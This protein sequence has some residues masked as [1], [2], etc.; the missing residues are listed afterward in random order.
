MILLTSFKILHCDLERGVK[1][2]R[3]KK[4]SYSPATLNFS[5]SAIVLVVLG[6]LFIKLHNALCE[7]EKS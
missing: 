2:I 6:P 7:D 1:A 4:V 5:Y 3:A